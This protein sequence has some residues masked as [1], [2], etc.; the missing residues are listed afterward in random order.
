MA[1]KEF[2]T[3]VDV[4]QSVKPLLRTA[5]VNGTGAD[6]QGYNS[7]MVVFETGVITDGTFTPKLQE[8]DDDSSYSDVAA[9]DYVGG[10]APTALAQNLVSRYGYVGAKRYI[11]AVFTV[12][13]SPAT[14]G[15]CSAVILRSHAAQNPLA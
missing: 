5:T 3:T 1:G 7:A 9:A 12:T 14:G 4:V 11:R 2:K 8:S 13:G 15:N 10:A 6:L